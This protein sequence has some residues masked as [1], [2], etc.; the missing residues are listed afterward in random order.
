MK[1]SRR[2]R[3][4]MALL[5]VLLLVAVM[6]VVAVA[7]LDDVRFSVRRATNLE[8]QSQAQWYA[9]GAETLARGQIDRLLDAGPARTPL[10]PAW[11]GRTMSFPIDGGT[12]T[13]AV[14]DGQAC[15]NLNSLVFGFGEDLTA[16]PLGAAQ[17]RALGRAVG[18]PDSRMQ[19]IADALT[20]WLDADAT[21]LPLG[22]EDGAYAGLAKPYR[23]GGVMLAEVS[24]LRA[25]KGVDA[26]TYRRLRPY[27]CALPTTRLSPLNV[28]T[29]TPEQAPLLTMLTGGVLAPQRAKALIAARPRD[30]WPDAA[31]FWAQ[32]AL[33]GVQVQP[34]ARE[35]ITVLTRFFDLR[36]DVELGGSH[37]VRTAL[38][39]AGADGRVRTVIQRWTPEE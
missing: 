21:A 27:V 12:I 13:A 11:N 14:T 29:L 6:S 24:E 38:L 25:V 16:R 20:D 30:G 17:F 28:N 26:E 4:G 35:Q 2:D 15:F 23:T 34:E 37:A 32:P 3:E 36:V 33:A 7:I 1:R 39:E 9:A 10:E 5:T 19:A 31:A 8:T 22:A 18:A